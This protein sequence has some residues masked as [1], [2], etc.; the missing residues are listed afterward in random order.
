MVGLRVTLTARLTDHEG[1]PLGGKEIIFYR[2]D[3]A[4][5]GFV[6][7]GRNI[8]DGD[9]VATYYDD[10]GSAGEYR[11]RAVFPGDDEYCGSADE[12]SVYIEVSLTESLLPV[13]MRMLMLMVI[14][15]VFTG[16]EVRIERTIEMLVRLAVYEKLI[17]VLSK[18]R[19]GG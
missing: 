4:A 3:S 7:L 14:S 16:R 1:N 13:L 6:E 18:M 17:S 15:S 8:T 5:G 19:S 10:V 12:V 2:Y 11:Y 9:G